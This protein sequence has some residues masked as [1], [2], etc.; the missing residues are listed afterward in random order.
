MGIAVLLGLLARQRYQPSF[1]FR[2][3]RRLLARSGSVIECCQRAIGHRPLHTTLDRLMMDAQS[4]PHRKERGILPVICARSTR[5]AASLRERA[6]AANVPI[7]SS[8]IPN[9]TACRHLAMMSLLVRSNTNEESTNESPVPWLPVSW[10]RSSSSLLVQAKTP[11]GKPVMM[12]VDPNSL[13]AEIMEPD[14]TT[15]SAGPNQNSDPA[16]R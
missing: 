10:N 16:H 11:A 12:I 9:S 14:S 13:T 7:S 8:L 2:R 1:G 3:N 4:L 6:M 5:R 15:G